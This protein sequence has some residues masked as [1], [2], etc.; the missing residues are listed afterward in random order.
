M[1]IT[2]TI[3]YYS[4]SC[5]SHCTT[6]IHTNTVQMS[7]FAHFPYWPS[8]R[9]LSDSFFRL[10]KHSH[11]RLPAVNNRFV[12]KRGALVLHTAFGTLQNLSSIGQN[13]WYI[14]QQITFKTANIYLHFQVFCT[15]NSKTIEI[16]NWL[17]LCFRF[18][19]FAN[20]LDWFWL[21]ITNSLTVAT[22]KSIIY[23]G[24]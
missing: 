20:E 21:K 8:V 15:G 19:S 9:S 6:V 24:R 11:I 5:L 22:T 16:T 3:P 12:F 7:Y 13:L 1:N 10:F 18:F 23:H 14:E 4:V 2:H 17:L